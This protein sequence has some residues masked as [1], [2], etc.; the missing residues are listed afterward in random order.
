MEKARAEGGCSQGPV[1]RWDPELP[2]G[3]PCSP[4][5]GG[6]QNRATE[7]ALVATRGRCR[8]GQAAPA[9]MALRRLLST[10]SRS[11]FAPRFNRS[12][13]FLQLPWEYVVPSR[14]GASPL[15]CKSPP[16]PE[17]PAA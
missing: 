16:K 2:G 6:G 1:G 17:R 12:L 9:R 14:A 5:L 11:P 4:C 15:A 13:R 10:G 7:S 8:P 3:F